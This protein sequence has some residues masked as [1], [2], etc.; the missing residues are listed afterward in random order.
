MM[1][2]DRTNKYPCPKCGGLGLRVPDHPHAFGYKAFGKVKCRK[3]KCGAVFDESKY[4]AWF[5]K[6]KERGE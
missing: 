4:E 1:K 2:L 3:K 5:E 6:R